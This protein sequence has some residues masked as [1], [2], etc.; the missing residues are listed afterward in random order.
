MAYAETYYTEQGSELI[1]I[2]WFKLTVWVRLEHN[3]GPEATLANW[4]M[5]S[6]N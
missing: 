3:I 1:E 4:A 2:Y 5:S 6:L